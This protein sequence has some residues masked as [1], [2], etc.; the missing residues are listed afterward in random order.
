MHKHFNLNMKRT[1]GN[2]LLLSLIIKILNFKYFQDNIANGKT[3]VPET[4]I[5]SSEPSVR[6]IVTQYL[7]VSGWLPGVSVVWFL[8][9]LVIWSY[10]W[11][12]SSRIARLRSFPDKNL[13]F[14]LISWSISLAN[15]L[16]VC[17][18]RVPSDLICVYELPRVFILRGWLAQSCTSCEIC[19]KCI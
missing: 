15:L 10:L 13:C 6:D 5:N 4:N 8:L 3:K 16:L 19:V 12:I 2:Y 9:R 7:N 17:E 1:I 14:V 11:C 18:V